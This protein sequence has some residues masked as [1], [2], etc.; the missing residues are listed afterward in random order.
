MRKKVV[1]FFLIATTSL[2]VYNFMNSSDNKQAPGID[3]ER[4]EYIAIG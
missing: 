3:I 4:Q 1:L 2:I